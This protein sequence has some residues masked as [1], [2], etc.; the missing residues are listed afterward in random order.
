MPVQ[1]ERK[2]KYDVGDLITIMSLLRGEGGCPWDREQDHHSIRKNFIEETYE[3]CEAID[4]DDPVLLQEELGDVLLQVAFHAR[5]EEEAG[6]F[7]FSDVCDG[8]CKKLIV[9]HPHVF[10]ETKVADSG[11]V[12]VNW[13]RIKERTKGQKTATET[14]RSVSAALPALMRSEKVQH[15]AAKVGFDYPDAGGALRDLESEVAE[16]REAISEGDAAHVCE[17]LG[18]VLFAAV[19][20]SRFTH[21]DAEQSLGQACEKFIDRFEQVETLARERDVDMRTAGIEKLD[22]LWKQAKKLNAAK[23]TD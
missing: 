21:V 11:E 18:D 19:N 20:V 3:V 8:I 23:T 7:D 9:R 2:Q 12:L 10:G 14:L 6:R 17:E 4:N 15:R 5:M 13:D 16:L 22:E 1:F